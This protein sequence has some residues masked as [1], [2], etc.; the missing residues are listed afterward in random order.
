MSIEEKIIMFN[1]FGIDIIDS[2][3]LSINISDISI[4]INNELKT[5]DKLKLLRT[6][7]FIVP[8]I[9]RELYGE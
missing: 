1:R 9:L 5:E 4:S 3:W 2:N 8:I 7:S 6:L